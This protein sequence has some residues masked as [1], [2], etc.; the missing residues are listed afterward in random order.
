[1]ERKR[2]QNVI[3]QFSATIEFLQNNYQHIPHNITQVNY[4]D[5]VHFVSG[6]E[7]G[8]STLD[9]LMRDME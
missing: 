9:A 3:F 5:D 2:I 8:A 6:E 7:Q 4:I 1:M